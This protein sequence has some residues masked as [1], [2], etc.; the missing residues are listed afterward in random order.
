[1]KKWITTLVLI[2]GLLA[3]ALP[4]EADEYFEPFDC[5]LTPPDMCE[6]PACENDVMCSGYRLKYLRN[7]DLK[8]TNASITRAIIIVH[9]RRDN[10][11]NVD[12]VPMDYYNRTVN[13]A[14]T[15]G[16]QNQTL[17]IA[18]FFTPAIKRQY[19]EIMGDGIGNED[20]VC[21]PGEACDFDNYTN[22]DNHRCKLSSEGGD[23]RLCWASWGSPV[24]EARDY[25][26]GG[27]AYNHQDLLATSSFLLMDN[28]IKWLEHAKSTGIFPNLA[29]IVVAGQS[30]GGQFVSRYAMAGS[31]D[32]DDIDMRYVAA[33]PWNV[34]YLTNVRPVREDI[35]AFPNFGYWGDCDDDGTEET[36][37]TPETDGR[38]FNMWSWSEYA[39]R[40]DIPLEGPRGGT[41]VSDG[42]YNRYP[43]GLGDIT[44]NEYMIEKVGTGVEA[45]E[46]YVGR[47][48]VLLYGIDDNLYVDKNNACYPPN[49]DPSDP[50]C[51][52]ALQGQ[53]RVER[54]A[55][56]FHQVCE[57]Y[58][59]SRKWFTT[60]CN[61][62]NHDGICEVS[63]NFPFTTIPC[64]PTGSPPC[65]KRLGHGGG[66]FATE[67]GHEV[68]FL[69]IM[70]SAPRYFLDIT[71]AGNGRGLVL[72]SPSGI[73]CGTVCSL[74]FS[75]N[76]EVIL[77]AIEDV[78]SDFAG[79][80]GDDD[81]S[82][83]VVTM[84]TAK[85]CT[86]TFNLEKRE[87]SVEKDGTGSGTVTSS[88]P[89]IDCGADCTGDY[90]YG[91]AVTLTAA[92]DTGSAFVRWSGDPDCTDNIVTMHENKTCTATFMLDYDNDGVPDDGDESG[93]VGD[94]PCTGGNTTDCDDNCLNDP[95]PDQSDFDG[96]LTGD[97]CDPDDDNDG[98]TDEEEAVIGTDPFN[99]DTDG[100]TVGDASDSCPL[101]DAT[102]LD[103][104][105]NGC[106]DSA[107]DLPELIEF[108]LGITEPGLESGLLDKANAVQEKIGRWGDSGS[109]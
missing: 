49:E 81:C 88:P 93:T 45:R 10:D 34:T 35:E 7:F 62:T 95:N 12:H 46:R 57:S 102:G 36:P 109:L 71:H 19:D 70:P 90:D 5:S 26:S 64:E 100:D 59:C 50:D 3:A 107:D 37:F 78:G 33:N 80:S 92:P 56:F 53:T 44:T 87:L 72:S 30:A 108:D 105:E 25:P 99:P 52:L 6:W 73:E 31:V 84:N 67:T 38:L 18:P 60:V 15:L 20:G 76:E 4:A 85:S 47:N 66:I 40:F 83:G 9:G 29:I 11:I 98:L 89:G 82:D 48:V 101:E 27:R 39:Y 23:N 96:D 22:V 63:D 51:E 1:M 75:Y 17:I 41:C 68:L 103:A 74:D 79:W 69:D 77:L 55:F 43:Y 58:D 94:N 61:D 14:T 104:D 106:I 91:T 54:G 24:S 42:S 65:D 2:I 8:T 16:L 13:S 21:D 28:I 86:A 97:A 32:P